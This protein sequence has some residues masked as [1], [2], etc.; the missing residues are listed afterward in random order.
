MLSGVIFDKSHGSNRL[1]MFE[2]SIEIGIGVG[3]IK[4]LTRNEVIGSI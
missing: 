1:Y 4:A 2:V 3:T